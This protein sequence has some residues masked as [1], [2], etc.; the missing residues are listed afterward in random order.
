LNDP[1]KAL[2]YAK[3]ARDLSPGDA[4]AT[5]VLGRIAYQTGNY[6]WAYSLLKQ[7]CD[8]LP[9]DAVAL[10]DLGWAAFSVGKVAE[11]TADMQRVMQIAPGNSIADDARTWLAMMQA[12]A[13]T[14]P[15]GA[16]D[17]AAEVLKKDPNYAPAQLAEAAITE[18]SG[19]ANRATTLYQQ[20]LARFP[21]YV[22]AQKHL[23][24]LYAGRGSD[25]TRAYDMAMKARKSLP[26]D[27]ELTRLLADISYR[28]KE[29]SRALELLQEAA[30]KEPL[31]A[32]HLYFMGICSLQ[33]NDIARAKEAL[34]QAL[35][36]GLKDPLANEA[37]RTLQSLK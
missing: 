35:A 36:N 25:L 33:T 27:A 2:E 24:I 19:D 3:T 18:R 21:D 4:H 34:T 22:P 28:R 32:E 10:H 15:P 23:A 29:Y 13:T 12:Q 1:A 31:D 17:P 5:L 6:S 37:R 7:T 30:R 16:A 11:A 26:E 9:D 8:Q 20:V 14:P